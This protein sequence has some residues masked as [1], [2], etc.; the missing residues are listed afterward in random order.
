LK[1]LLEGWFNKME[2]RENKVKNLNVIDI[3]QVAL[4]AAMV[5][6]TTYVIEI[7][8]GTKAVL[9]IGDTMVFA[10]AII[11]G[12][13]KAALASAIGMGL[14]DLLSPYAVWAPFTFIIKGVMAYIASSI[15]Y[16]K[17]YEGN[18]PVNN[19]FGFIIAGI[20]MIA[21]YFFAGAIIYHNF[22]QAFLDIQWNVLQVVAG[23]VLAIPL[24]AALKKAK[25]KVK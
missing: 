1:E 19:I 12:N 6:V 17:N 15:A 13:K 7:P 11:L 20:W 22:A 10:G 18:N 9:H 23:I 4:M 14:F 21:G 25:I 16:R 5:F 8:V 24:I 2:R 3:V